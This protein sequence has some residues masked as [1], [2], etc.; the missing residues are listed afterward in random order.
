M[1]VARLGDQIRAPEVLVQVGAADAAEL[2]GDLDVAGFHGRDGDLFEADVGLVVE[3][4]GV[5][6]RHC[7][8]LLGQD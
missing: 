3:A 4:G 6:C 1:R 2:G 7:G 5:H 8:G